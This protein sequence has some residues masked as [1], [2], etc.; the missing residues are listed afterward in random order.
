MKHYKQK[1]LDLFLTSTN[2]PFIDE[3][4]G[5]S[6][7]SMLV[8]LALNNITLYYTQEELTSIF[9]DVASGKKGSSEL[10]HWILSYQRKINI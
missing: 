7:H 9:L 2:H 1:Q 4:K 6:A 3:N 10:L 8:F 5:I